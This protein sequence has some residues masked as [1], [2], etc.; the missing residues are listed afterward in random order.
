MILGLE[1]VG[2]MSSIFHTDFDIRLSLIMTHLFFIPTTFHTIL[3]VFICIDNKVITKVS[4]SL[5]LWTVKSHL[6][7][8]KDILLYLK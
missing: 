1:T 7:K 5:W 2:N 8:K 6:N 3:K 4:S